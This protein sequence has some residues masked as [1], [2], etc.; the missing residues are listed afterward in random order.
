MQT[1]Y[2]LLM[3]IGVLTAIVFS[4][5]VFLTGKGDAMSGGGSVRTSFKGKATFDD[6]MSKTTLYLGGAFMLIM[7]LID[8]ISNRLGK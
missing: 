1:A 6:I 2:N 5:L 3:G 7:V 8:A 4:A